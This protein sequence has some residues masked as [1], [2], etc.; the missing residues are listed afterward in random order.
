[1]STT[2]KIIAISEDVKTDENG[3]QY[4]EM[5][6]PQISPK[7]AKDILMGNRDY[8]KRYHLPNIT[9]AKTPEAIYEAIKNLNELTSSMLAMCYYLKERKVQ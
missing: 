9:K 7:M 5:T 4:E 8:I 3:V 6:A 2:K 1:M